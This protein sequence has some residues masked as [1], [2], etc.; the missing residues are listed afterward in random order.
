MSNLQTHIVDAGVTFERQ[1][2][3]TPLQLS[4]GTIHELT[5]ANASVTVE[6]D[7][8]RATGYGTIYLS[9]LWAWPDPALLH[10]Y[11]DT[12]LRDFC[13]ETAGGLIELCGPPAHPLELGL[14]L[15]RAVCENDAGW[16]KPALARA[17]CASPFDA[18]IHDA[19]GQALGTSAFAFYREAAAIPSGDRFFP[20]GGA[21]KAIS[22]ILLSP[23][24]RALDAWLIVGKDDRLDPDAAWWIRERGYHCFK[25]KTLGHDPAED[26]ARTAAVYRGAQRAGVPRP[27]L[28]VDSNE[29]NADAGGVAEYLDKLRE[30]DR[31]AFDAVEYLEQPTSRDILKVRFDWRDVARRKPVLLDEGLTE[32][33]MLDEAVAQGW[34]GLALKTCKG[35]S[36]CLVAAAWA[37][38]RGLVIAVQDL[39]N[40]GL[41]L[42]H[43]ALLAAHVP[44]INGAEL[45]SPQFTPAANERW[46]P[47]LG[48]LFDPQSGVHRLSFPIP[49]GLGSNL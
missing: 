12:A 10:S 3:K 26:A 19:A 33:D 30:T 47:R 38:E 41:A 25:L 29:G 22:R 45:N 37:F 23:P 7:G 15:H 46:L 49:P 17:M 27:R 35:H 14:R 32:L 18:A 2:L 34:S 5:Q 4:S 28:S 40:P 24:R 43:S 6:V 48:A 20:S 21:C 42:I 11:R 16:V 36:F 9:G 13:T 44:S 8:R 1:R 39:T 31:E